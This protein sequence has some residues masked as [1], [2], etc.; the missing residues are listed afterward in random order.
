V[1]AEYGLFAPTAQLSAEPRVAI[2]RFFR[3]VGSIRPRHAIANAYVATVVRPHVSGAH[4]VDQ[5]AGA[6][7]FESPRRA[8]A[9]ALMEGL[10]RFF[11]LDFWE[12][13]RVVRARFA[14]VRDEALDPRRA[15]LY[16]E[17]QYAEPGFPLRRFDPSRRSSGSGECGCRII[18]RSWC[19]STFV[20]SAAGRRLYVP[21]SSG[22]ACPQLPARCRPERPLT[23]S[24]SAT[25]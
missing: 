17:A 9:L 6:L 12:Q 4:R 3:D 8:E 22:A 13:R 2:R 19:R 11:T 23:R 24:W 16:D 25:R 20:F 15:P 5:L 18:R 7:D 21:T 10:E 14:A 1:G